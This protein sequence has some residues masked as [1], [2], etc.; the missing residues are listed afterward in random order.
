[1]DTIKFVCPNCLKVNQLPNKPSYTKANCGNCKSSLLGAKPIDA[2]D[3]NF[4]DIINSTNVPVVVD[5]WASWCGPCKM[6]APAFTEA[7][8]EMSPKAQFVK[9][10]TDMAPQVSS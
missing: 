10:N 6:M 4:F 7:S 5:F 9:V 3:R 2:D 1:M 8:M